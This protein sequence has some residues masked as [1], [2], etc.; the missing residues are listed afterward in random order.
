VDE[1]YS[2]GGAE[3]SEL[4]SVEKASDFL[5]R[6]GVDILV[7]N[8]GT[9]HRQ[10]SKQ[11]IYAADQ[12]RRISSE[13]GKILCLHGTSSVN[14]EYIPR[15]PEDGFIKINIFTTLA[16]HGGQAVTREVLSNI[17]NI[18]TEE[19]ICELVDEGVLGKGSLQP[20][21]KPQL[22]NVAN[23]RRRDAW[24]SAVKEQCMQYLELLNYRNW[25]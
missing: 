17:T 18:L 21:A 22:I 5:S 7:P 20:G 2:D 19:K 11:I 15:L 6:T 4:T 25:K 24:F 9:E 12:A 10:T 14:K 1:I 16:V 13:V 3:K 8:V 23:P